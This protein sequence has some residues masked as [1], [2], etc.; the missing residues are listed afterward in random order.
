[1]QPQAI[2]LAAGQTLSC[3]RDSVNR[4]AVEQAIVSARTSIERSR[5]PAAPAVPSLP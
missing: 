3:D 5:V 2:Q 1:M 4:D